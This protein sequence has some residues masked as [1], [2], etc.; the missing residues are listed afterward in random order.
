[1]RENFAPE[2]EAVIKGSDH[3]ALD[4]EL[5]M[6]LH[7]DMGEMR[8]VRAHIQRLLYLRPSE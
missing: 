5:R 8:E 7:R 3:I 6:A 1:V 2:V 4:P